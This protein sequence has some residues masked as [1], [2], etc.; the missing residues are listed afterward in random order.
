MPVAYRDVRKSLRAGHP[1]PVRAR[2]GT[3][4]LRNK[5]ILGGLA[6][7]ILGMSAGS[8]RVVAAFGSTRTISFF[9]IHTKETLTITYKKD[10]QYD[11]EALKKIDWLMR[12]WRQNKAVEMDPK[13]IDLLWEMHT[14][15]GSKEPIHV[16]CGHRSEAT[17]NMLRRTRGGQAK[18]SKH[19]TGQAI[20]AAFPDIPLKQLRWSAAIREVGG[21]GYYPTSGIPFVHVDTGP[22]R[23]WPR[24]PRSELALLFPDGRTKHR[25]ADGGSLTR[26]DARRA[27]ANTDV[28][29]Q[30]AAYFDLRN[31]TRSPIEIA[32]AETGIAPPAPILK[33]P[34]A[35]VARRAPEA[36]VAAFETE[37]F[38][39]AP[40]EA[41]VPKLV[42]APRPATPPP[43]DAER[44]RLDQLVTLASLS[45]DDVP[46][47]R[48]QTADAD[49]YLLDRL[50]DTASFETPAPR[51]QAAAMSPQKE[52]QVASLDPAAGLDPPKLGSTNAPAEG[53]APAPEFDDDHPEELSYRP[54]PVAPL[55]T[56]SAS[57]DDEALVKIVHPNLERTLDLLDDKQIV[58]PMRLRPGDQ[59]SGVLWAQQF[60]GSAVDFRAHETDPARAAA[61]G[62]TSRPVKTT[63]R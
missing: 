22:V 10:G 32:Q 17:N 2:G 13:T 36:R 20:D 8:P 39:A 44:G 14:E 60:Q 1:R 30:V 38:E 43:S 26:D 33:A 19:M 18:K 34:P 9:H 11:R 62:L 29:R 61:S 21:I 15:L 6:A 5:A 41:P 16:I 58:L 3:L 35:Q 51:L 57:A 7:V 50:V 54:F 55:L 12:D 45:P 59:I 25:P 53:W 28:A 56:Q 63:G 47:Q 49:R 46:A 37:V 24:L 4:V 48:L 27:R 52:A 23:A 31:R 40:A 42:R